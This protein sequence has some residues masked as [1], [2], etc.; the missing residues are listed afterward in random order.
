MSVPSEHSSSSVCMHVCMCMCSK[1]Q[2]LISKHAYLTYAIDS[3]LSECV[4][5]TA[6]TLV[7][8]Y[9]VRAGLFTEMEIIITLIYICTIVK[10]SVGVRLFLYRPEQVL[11]SLFKVY[12]M[13]HWQEKEPRLLR[14][15]CWQSLVASERHSSMSEK[16]SSLKGRRKFSAI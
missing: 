1:T 14:Q 5:S 6:G 10:W 3:V 16:L 4:A 2:L 12:P 9:S 11:P 13:L 8:A 7:R 15:I